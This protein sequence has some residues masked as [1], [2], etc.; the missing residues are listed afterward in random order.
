M[1]IKIKQY[2]D[3][4]CVENYEDIAYLDIFYHGTFL[5]EMISDGFVFVRKNRM[6]ITHIELDP[7]N[8][9]MTYSG[10]LVIDEIFAY[11]YDNQKY[12]VYVSRV[13]DEIQTI[14]S[15]WSD[16]TT[17]YEDYNKTNKYVRNVKTTIKRKLGS[18]KLIQIKI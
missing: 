14:K 18:K 6:I 3:E 9:L 1:N 17:K 12:P 7:S 13:V 15:T 4:I 5:G 8:V 16:S 2:I 10:N 11:T